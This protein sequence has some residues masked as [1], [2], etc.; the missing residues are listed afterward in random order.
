MPASLPCQSSQCVQN[1]AAHGALLAVVV[2]SQLGLVLE[3][4]CL[5]QLQT[6]TVTVQLQLNLKQASAFGLESPSHLSFLPVLL[7]HAGT[8]LYLTVLVSK[9]KPDVVPPAIESMMKCLEAVSCMQLFDWIYIG[10]VG[11]HD[12]D[13]E[14]VTVRLSPDATQVLGIYYSA[15][16]YSRASNHTTGKAPSTI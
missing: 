11:A 15:H 1:T 8:S 6:Y 4:I 2:W 12:G 9:V 7:T 13:W 14:H 16:R 3:Q 5:W 10:E